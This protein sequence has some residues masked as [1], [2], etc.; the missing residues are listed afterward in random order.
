VEV[1]S[2]LTTRIFRLYIPGQ[3][4]QM[5][6]HRGGGK[7]GGTGETS[8]FLFSVSVL[9]L[10]QSHTAKTEAENATGLGGYPP[11]CEHR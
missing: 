5:K 2:Q 3:L 7:A 6:G 1:Y 9:R 8:R 10:L 4:A 11:V